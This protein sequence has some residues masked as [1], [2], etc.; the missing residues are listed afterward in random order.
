MKKHLRSRFLSFVLLGSFVPTFVFAQIPNDP[1]VSQWA[2]KDIGAYAAWDLST[3]SRNVVVAIIDNGFDSN[4]PDLKENV[5][6]NPREIPN[7][8]IDDDNNGYIDDIVGWNF[9]PTDSNGD[10]KIR[11][12]EKK[13]SN[14]P[15]PDVSEL[16]QAEKDQGFFHHAT[17]VAGLVGAV[18][19][20]KKDSAGINWK[21]SLMNLKVLGNTGVGDYTPLA[22]AIFYAVN[23]GADVINISAVGTNSPDLDRAVEYAYGHG[24]VV[25][26]AAGNNSGNLNTS[27]LYPACSDAGASAEKQKVLGVSAI[28]ETHHLADFSNFGSD[29]ID[30]TAPG[31]HMGSL[32]RYEPSEGLTKEWADGWNGTSFATPLVSGAAALIKAVQP[33]WKAPEIYQ[34]LLKSTHKTPTKDESGYKTSFGFGLLQVDK[35]VKYAVDHLPAAHVLKS[36]GLFDAESGFLETLSSDKKITTSTESYLR[37]VTLLKSFKNNGETQY[38]TTRLFQGNN[39]VTIYSQNWQK[40]QRWNLSAQVKGKILVDNFMG[41]GQANIVIVPPTD[42]DPLQVFSLDGKKLASTKVDVH[43]TNIL[44]AMLLS[45]GKLALVSKENGKSFLQ[46]FD[47]TFTQKQDIAL[48]SLGTIVQMDAFDMDGDKSLDYVFL[49]QK[50]VNATMSIVDEKGK[51]KGQFPVSS[52]AVASDMQ[53]VIGDF[54]GDKKDDIITLEKNAK[55]LILWKTNG[56]LLSRIPFLSAE[57]QIFSLIPII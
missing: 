31:V 44:S 3:G 45:G 52:S 22:E 16:S 17:L 14:D 39:Q 4:H 50:G 30:I 9:I 2:F 47:N 57:N 28:D 15:V 12:D 53:F 34:A 42:A 51:L 40:L 1:Y 55:S 38:L 8:K 11:G 20:N 41:T 19:N 5:W 13:G 35:A 27:S 37:K 24:V 33:E 26:A 6:K 7:N 43:G 10:G 23:N 25:V 29:C 48:T 21:V 54:N 18:G 32:L 56:V 49:T 36:L 46:V